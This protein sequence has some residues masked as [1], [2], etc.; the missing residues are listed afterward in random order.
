MK[1]AH[2][3][4]EAVISVDGETV[5]TLVIENQVFFR[6]LLQDI[7]NQIEGMEGDTVLSQD[8]QLIAFSR[9]AE[10]IDSYLGFSLN[11]NNCLT[12]FLSPGT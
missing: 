7:A 2:P 6:T 10:L 4:M 8:D 1:L 9:S 12:R 5:P 3:H 11:R